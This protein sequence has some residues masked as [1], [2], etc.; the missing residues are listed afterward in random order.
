M[1]TKNGE[2][3]EV[4]E[5]EALFFAKQSFVDDYVARAEDE[6]Q[7]KWAARIQIFMA[8]VAARKL[9]VVS[10]ATLF[11]LSRCLS[12]LAPLHIRRKKKRAKKKLRWWR[13]ICGSPT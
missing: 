1:F 7:R 8:K 5:E 2:Q 11:F 12:Y 13:Q 10:Q 6:V 3:M 9:D 4:N